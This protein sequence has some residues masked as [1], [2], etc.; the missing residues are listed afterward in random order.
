LIAADVEYDAEGRPKNVDRLLTALLR[1]MPELSSAT[2]RATGSAEGGVRGGSSTA[3][4]NDLIRS[5][6][7]RA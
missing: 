3:N 2:A 7:G 4:M 6:A 5:A 1:D